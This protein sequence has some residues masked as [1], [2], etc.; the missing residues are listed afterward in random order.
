M[1][2]CPSVRDGYKRPD[3]PGSTAGQWPGP[4]LVGEITTI[5]GLWVDR[6]PLG[7]GFRWSTENKKNAPSESVE[8]SAAPSPVCPRGPNEG[9]VVR[10]RLAIVRPVQMPAPPSLPHRLALPG[11][12]MMPI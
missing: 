3:G 4:I 9:A 2:G 6:V 12:A 11:T 10:P 1:R 5:G 7:S 8:G